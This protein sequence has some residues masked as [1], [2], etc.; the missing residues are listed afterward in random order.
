MVAR[1]LMRNLL[2]SV[3]LPEY[4]MRHLLHGGLV[5]LA[6]VSAAVVMQ[7][8]ETHARAHRRE[9]CRHC[10]RQRPECRCPQYDPCAITENCAVTPCPVVPPVVGPPVAISQTTIR[11]VTETRF[12]HRPIRTTR[13][14]QETHYR[15]EQYTECVPQTTMECIT[16]DEGCYQMVWVPKPVTKQVPKTIMTQRVAC[17]QVPFTVTRN[18]TECTTQCV[19]IQTTRYVCETTRLPCV[20]TPYS[21]AS[22][23]V[24]PTCAVPSM[25]M[26]PPG[27]QAQ[28]MFNSPTPT[29]TPVPEP[30][31]VSLGQPNFSNPNAES[32]GKAAAEGK[33]GVPSPSAASVWRTRGI[34]R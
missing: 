18:I 1:L 21:A 9:C 26:M 13:Q 24:E 25:P 28:P 5:L 10:R 14:V 4:T 15:N 12:V 6:F 34:A 31:P 23:P 11:P 17:R 2:I 30:R 22:P 7:P 32:S 19:P 16:V 33:H 8:Q 20:T 3:P 27:G 29:T